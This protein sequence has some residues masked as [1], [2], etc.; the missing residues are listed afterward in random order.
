MWTLYQVKKG[1]PVEKAVEE[2]RAIGM[3]A[4]RDVEPDASSDFV[5]RRHGVASNGAWAPAV[6]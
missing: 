1:V 4:D 6:T 2:G 5:L 3:K